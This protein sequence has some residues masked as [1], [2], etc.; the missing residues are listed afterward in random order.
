MTEPA[1]T[2]A[3]NQIQ[4][5]I[6]DPTA[7]GAYSNLVLSNITPEEI[8]LDFLYMQP[9]V[10]KARVRS[11]V[12]MTPRHAKRLMAMLAANIADY[13]TQFGPILDDPAKPGITLSFN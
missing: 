4:V 11:R 9:Q 6:D 7:Q 5:D 8:V 2:P 10:S 1:G 13:E 3:Q 12:I